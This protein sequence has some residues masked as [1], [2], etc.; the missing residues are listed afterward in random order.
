[1][2]A[3][4]TGVMKYVP[5]YKPKERGKFDWFNARCADAQEKETKRGRDRKKKK[6]QRNKDFKIARN[7]YVKIRREE[8]K[9]YEKDIVEK[10]KEEPKLFYKI[11]NG[12]IKPKEKIERLKDGNMI[13]EDPKD[14]T[15]LLNKRFQQVFTKESQFNEPQDDMINVKMDEVILTKEEIYKIMEELEVRKAIGLD[16][17]GFTLKE[18]RNQLVGPVYDIKCFCLGS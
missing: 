9:G 11:I 12:K 5:L 4:E 1:M 7:E 14:M 16:S 10:C 15:E 2:D 3:Y 13:T 18:C 6:N 8:E 17:P